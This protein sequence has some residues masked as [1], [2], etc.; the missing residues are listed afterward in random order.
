MLFLNQLMNLKG[1]L[2]R[3]YFYFI[4]RYENLISSWSSYD[5][6]DGS[7]DKVLQD[8]FLNILI[9]WHLNDPVSQK[10]N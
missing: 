9:N 7:S 10:G 1:I 6:F 5:M 4:T 3:I 2:A 8:T